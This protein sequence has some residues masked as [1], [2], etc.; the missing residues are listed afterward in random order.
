MSKLGH[1]G[2]WV[3]V[4]YSVDPPAEVAEFDDLEEFAS[5]L[6]LNGDFLRR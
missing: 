2:N 6:N 3:V 1:R 5:E 4:D